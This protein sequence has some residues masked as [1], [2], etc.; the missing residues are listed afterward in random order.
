MS[1]PLLLFGHRPQPPPS[2]TPTA[3]TTAPPAEAG[4]SAPALIAP[5][6]VAGGAPPAA[7]PSGAGS[8]DALASTPS[9]AAAAAAAAAVETA[10]VLQQPAVESS[11]GGE[12]AEGGG[13][14]VALG[15]VDVKAALPDAGGAVGDTEESAEEQVCQA[16]GVRGK[17]GRMYIYIWCYDM[18]FCVLCMYSCVLRGRVGRVDDGC[19]FRFWVCFFVLFVHC[20]CN[21]GFS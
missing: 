16:L 8:A 17:E 18:Y 7:A 19:S 6:A 9:A 12:A 15:M 10:A 1:F 5:A 20:G 13:G 21:A 4:T 11:E 14:G 3:S 2:S